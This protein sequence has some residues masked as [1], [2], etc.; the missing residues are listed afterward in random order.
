M[1]GVLFLFVIFEILPLLFGAKSTIQKNFKDFL[2]YQVGRGTYAVLVGGIFVYIYFHY[3]LNIGFIDISNLPHISQAIII[4][5]FAELCIY[6][7][8]MSAH[9]YNTP[10]IAKAH[11][12]HHTVKSDLEWVN[13]KKEHL[14]VIA[15]F[16][17]VFTSMCYI[18]FKSSGIAHLLVTSTYLFLNS[19]SHYHKPFS[20]PYLDY[21]FLFPKDH[22]RHHTERISGPYGVTL[23]LFDTLFNTR[24]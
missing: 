21:I 19:F 12:F 2:L 14:V 13:A 1:M 5:F 11:R 3:H 9:V 17:F 7:A 10:I 23:S 22:L 20:I 4:Y 15:L 24:H 18:I 6:F 8:H 16:M